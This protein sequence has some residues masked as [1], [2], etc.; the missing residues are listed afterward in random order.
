MQVSLLERG[1]QQKAA[2]H[3][4]VARERKSSF[5]LDGNNRHADEEGEGEDESEGRSCKRKCAK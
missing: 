5:K 4:E 1:R 3:F 2:L